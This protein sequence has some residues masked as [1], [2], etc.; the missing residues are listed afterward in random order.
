MPCYQLQSSKAPD[1][2][3]DFGYIGPSPI[4]WRAQEHAKCMA[5]NSFAEAEAWLNEIGRELKVA[6]HWLA[7]AKSAAAQGGAK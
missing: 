5:S 4:E 3:F 2:E 1:N 6:C 7:V